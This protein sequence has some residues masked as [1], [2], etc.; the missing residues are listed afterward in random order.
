MLFDLLLFVLAL[1]P[2]ALLSTLRRQSHVL[3]IESDASRPAP[4][5]LA[6]PIPQP[7][8]LQAAP[9]VLLRQSLEP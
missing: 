9:E 7:V 3:R 2:L 1:L 8:Q 5:E 6:Q 4:G